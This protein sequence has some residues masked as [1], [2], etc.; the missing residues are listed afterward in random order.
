MI[1]K[2]SY[3]V[4]IK[5][6]TIQEHSTS[7]IITKTTTTTTAIATTVKAEAPLQKSHSTPTSPTTAS[8]ESQPHK[9]TSGEKAVIN[10]TKPSRKPMKH[11]VLK[12][13][14]T[15]ANKSQQASNVK[16]DKEEE[17]EPMTKPMSLTEKRKRQAKRADQVKI[18]KVRE[19]RE[20][21]EARLVIRRQI[22][23][24]TNK[25]ITQ[26]SST[27]STTS[28]IRKKKKRVKFNFDK[29]SVI[30]LPSFHDNDLEDI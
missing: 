11:W 30:E 4:P 22:V 28:T 15:T 1:P 17:D 6:I 27:S 26:S 19:E 8:S 18:W 5:L 23:N 12:K 16:A 14:S 2:K 20:A 9:P 25:K 29:N 21:R 10:T 7:T 24:G 13:K 3:S